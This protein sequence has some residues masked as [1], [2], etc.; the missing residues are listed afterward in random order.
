[1]NELLTQFDALAKNLFD[2]K[3]FYEAA[4]VLEV[5]INLFPDN[6]ALY[7]NARMC[8]FHAN[9]LTSVLRIVEHQEKF[10]SSTL[11]WS[12]FRDKMS[13]QRWLGLYEESKY[14][15]QQLG[16]CPEKWLALGW[17]LLRENKF[18]EGFALTEKA[19]QTPWLAD[20]ITP[21]CTRW[22]GENLT[23]K[24]VM[25][26][27][28]SGIGDEIIFSRWIPEIQAQAKKVY[29]YTNKEIGN[30][31]SRNFNIEVVDNPNL[32]NCDFWIPMMSLPY[33]LEVDTPLPKTYIRLP[34]SNKSSNSIRIGINWTG[35]SNHVENHLRSIPKELLIETY[36]PFGEIVELQPKTIDT[37]WGDTFNLI[38]S[39]DLI[40]TS[41]TS[42]AHAAASTGKNT[43][44]LNGFADYFTWCSTEQEGKSEW[45]ENTWCIRQ[46][47]FGNWK[48]IVEQ[49]AVLSSKILVTPL[50]N[51][52]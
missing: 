39:C 33:L 52:V 4:K 15:A 14:T 37:T 35:N 5:A 49:S 40:V 45:Y 19:R 36:Q 48:E 9:D 22:H 31:I 43:I 32:H 10:A 7:D 30:V 28:E 21:T 24:T 12:A 50:T 47:S 27:A 25:L 44:V 20:R 17:H 2:Q 23:N 42:I 26:V 6:L 46:K 41:C 16:E 18:K 11:S 13:S 3:N 1:V 29:Y 34:T 51:Q 8:S 38:N